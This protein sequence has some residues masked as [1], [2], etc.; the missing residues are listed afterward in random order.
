MVF[1]AGFALA[2]AGATITLACTTSAPQPPPRPT[3]TAA[4]V[5]APAGLVGRILYSKGGLDLW[6]SAPD[7]AGRAALTTDGVSGGGYAGGRWSPDGSLVAAERYPPGE[8]GTALYLVRP[9]APA[10]RLTKTD[11]FLDGYVWSRDGRY[12]AYGMVVSGITA[13]AGGL[14]SVGA[15]G[16]VHLYD[17]RTGTDLVVGPG[18]HP[19]F[20]P[21]GHTLGYAHLSGA[22][23]AAD[24]SVLAQ[25]TTTTLPT[26]MLV[27]LPDLT[28]VSSTVAPRGMG[29]IGGPQYSA[30]G[31]YIAYAAIE[32]GPILEA[33]QI[34]YVQEAIAGAPPKLFVLGKTGAIHHVA[35]LRWSP[36][37]PLLAYSI[38]NAQPHHHWLEVIN[39]VTGERRELFDSAKHFLDYSWSPD[40]KTILL[41]VDDGD[42]WL[43]F[44]PD[45]AGPIGSVTPGGWRPE[46][47]QCGR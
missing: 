28:R 47:C 1:R 10:I 12:L 42:E 5:G 24:L 26:R 30:D 27:T 14:T 45:H 16:D 40:G 3:S 22:I 37:A 21:D 17:T 25:G 15:V 23:A 8:G 33:E 9:A 39:A 20:S 13:A 46:W 35:D 11:T 2:L 44:T 7:G 19:A 36:T 32:N 18:T 38:I 34:V 6:S 43:Y 31:K 29:L 41:Q 4:P